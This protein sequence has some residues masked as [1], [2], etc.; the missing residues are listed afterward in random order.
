[1]A[2]GYSQEWSARNSIYTAY[3]RIYYATSY[4][5][6]TNTSTVT[7]T[8]QLMTSADFGNDYRIFN[9]AGLSG[10]GV[11]G[12]GVC[13]YSFGTNYGSGN[14]LSCGSAHS[15]YRDLGSWSFTVSHNADGDASFTVG[16]CGSVLAMYFSGTGYTY[17]QCFIGSVGDTV[18]DTITIHENA[19][20]SIASSSASVTT[21]G[22][23]SLT[24]NRKASSN[25]HVVTFL[26]NNS[27]VLYSSG[28]FGTSYTLDIPR[29]FFRNYPSLSSLP[30]TVSVQ[31]YNSSGTAIGSP[32]TT[33]LTIYADA[34]MKPVVSSGWV[35]LAPYNTGAVSGFTGYVQGYSRA[36]A[37]FNSSKISMTNAVG[38]SIASYSVTCQ[39]ATDNTS[40]YQTGV[41]S[42]T[43]VSVVCTVTDTRG[44]SA[45]QTFTLTVMAYAKP[46]LTGISI[47]RCNTN[48]AASED[49]T[50]YSAKATLTYSSLNS[51]NRATLVCAVAAAGGSYGSAEALTSGQARISTANL[52]ADQSYTVR[53]TA[54]DAL[55]N[56]DVYYQVL[57]TR[58]WAMKFRPKGNGVAFGKAA[59]YDN[60]FEIT[61][62]WNVKFGHPLPISSGG[63][64]AGNAADARANLGLGN[65]ENVRQYS[66]QNPPPYPV[67]SVNG[68]TGDVAVQAAT[69]AQV[70]T[71]VN[72]WLGNNVDPATG[73]VL[74]STLTM[75]NAAPPASAVGELKSAFL[76]Q[77]HPG[78]NVITD[79]IFNQG[80]Y[81]NSTA[82]DLYVVDANWGHTDKIAI[83][84][85][86]TYFINTPANQYISFYDSNGDFISGLAGVSATAPATAAYIRLSVFKTRQ[87][88]AKLTADAPYT[89]YVRELQSDFEK[90]LKLQS[91]FEKTLKTEKLIL[92]QENVTGT[93]VKN[94]G[95]SSH[96]IDRSYDT[97]VRIRNDSG[98]SIRV[99][100][101]LTQ[102]GNNVP[103][104]ST[105]TITIPAGTTYEKVFSAIQSEGRAYGSAEGYFTVSYVGI[106][107]YKFDGGAI[108]VEISNKVDPIIDDIR[109]KQHKVICDPA[110]TGGGVFSNIQNAIDWLKAHYNVATTPCTVFLMNGTYTLNYVSSRNAVIDKG[111]NRISIVGES[112]D[113]VKL[114]LTSTPAQNNKI[115]EHGGPS[116]IENVSFFNLWNAD[117]S[118][119]SYANNSYCIH[120]DIGFTTDEVYDTV[121]K[122]CYVYSEAFAPIGA[123][124]WKNQKQRYIDVEAVFNSL[125]ERPNGYN[126]WAP[127]YI[128][129]PSQPNQPNCSVEIDGCTC[130]AQK[131]TM[132][133]VLSNV[134]DRTPYTEIPVSIR[135][136]IG[137]TTG[138]T[139]TN[140][141]KATHDLQPDSALN[142]VDAWN[143]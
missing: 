90:T 96:S 49:G 37:T 131:G 20:S 121:V 126:Q 47:F 83:T 102:A 53:I 71:A 114:V 133:I 132:A 27:T 8:P 138:S 128:H 129:G 25:Y 33:S 93:G 57:P 130:I 22:T 54:T 86:K 107:L 76:R 142:N 103:S 91:D 97:V 5:A 84:G 38:A 50:K 34:D 31:T 113:G 136:T 109:E 12:N 70:A 45:S 82:N 24:M 30:V 92:A 95:D 120:N 112:R 10:A 127:I 108:A 122:N 111:A 13:L 11:Y 99:E 88:V 85:G 143:Y 39:G 73:Y 58:K 43:S 75:S 141:S 56:T 26:Y 60:T 55:G 4:N 14:Y 3:F 59:E 51:Q 44:R 52:N 29:S 137:T 81:Y 68:Q 123:G 78:D 35:S 117:G 105:G 135:R 2:T 46:K 9:G 110:S 32:A 6:S 65:V 134:P 7:I 42:S 140:V 98:A 62:D 48:G 67:R 61:A 17:N 63:T 28:H 36:Q 100:L 66:A 87:A 115:I 41:L 1:M 69:D 19:A 77:T 94:F 16:I 104:S 89:D 80:A 79:L 72:T 40:P 64:A 119:P 23:Y 106:Y 74:D 21:Q 139:I 101:Q 124:L 116:I 125:D 18:S 118:T 15:Y